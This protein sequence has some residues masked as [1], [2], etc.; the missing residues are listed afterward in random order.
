M[1][2]VLYINNYDSLITYNLC[3]WINLWFVTAIRINQDTSGR[4]TA[5]RNIQKQL[6]QCLGLS[7]CS[8]SPFLKNMCWSYALLSSLECAGQPLLMKG[9][10]ITAESNIPEVNFL[11]IYI[12]FIFVPLIWF[13]NPHPELAIQMKGTNSGAGSD[14]PGCDFSKYSRK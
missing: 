10:E 1:E 8:F 2:C 7:V 3:A 14:I 13:G 6:F 5:S 9:P 12:F 4:T 11:R